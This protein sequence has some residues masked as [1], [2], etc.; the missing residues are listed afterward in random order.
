MPVKHWSLFG[1]TFI[2]IG[3]SCIDVTVWGQSGWCPNFKFNR[4][5]EIHRLCPISVGGLGGEIE[6][7]GKKPDYGLFFSII[8]FLAAFGIPILQTNGVDLNWQWSIVAYLVIPAVWIWTFL[9]HAS[10]HRGKLSR[11]FGS[12]CIFVL[13]GSMGIYAV[14]KEMNREDSAELEEV[15]NIQVLSIESK[16]EVAGNLLFSQLGR[17]RVVLSQMPPLLLELRREQ[18]LLGHEQTALD[19]KANFP[20]TKS[21]P[22]GYGPTLIVEESHELTPRDGGIF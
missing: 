15:R 22:L 5:T 20:A 14:K 17:T 10:P 16:Q 4:N 9:H 13:A 3:A 2:F 8:S 11:I 1:L 18:H 12:L 21:P 6:N 19:F 7:S